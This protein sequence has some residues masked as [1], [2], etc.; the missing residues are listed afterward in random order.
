MVHTF[1]QH[2]GFIDCLQHFSIKGSRTPPTEGVLFAGVLAYGCNI[3]ITKIAY[4]AKN[5]SLSRLENAINWYFSIDNL[6]QAK[7]QILRLMVRLNL[8]HVTASSVL[9]RLNSYSQKHPVYQSLRELGRL[10]R[11]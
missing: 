2:C 9:R 4:T 10:V 7:D 3:G 1:N 11:I 8:K 5:L 6:R